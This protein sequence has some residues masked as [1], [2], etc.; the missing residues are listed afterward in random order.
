MKRARVNT[1]ASMLT[2]LATAIGLFSLTFIEDTTPRAQNAQCYVIQNESV[3]DQGN[4]GT[5]T[6]DLTYY[7]SDGYNTYNGDA[8]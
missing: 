8:G 4:C 1:S 3:V 2:V 6:Y 5:V 7:A